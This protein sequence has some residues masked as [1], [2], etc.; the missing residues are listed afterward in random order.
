M[1]LEIRPASVTLSPRESQ[2]FQ[3]LENGSPVDAT[4]EI[5]PK[6]KGQLK[7][8]SVYQAPPFF[9]TSTRVTLVA[10]RNAD[11]AT[12]EILLNPTHLWIL[13][14][15]AY[16]LATTLIAGVAVYRLWPGADVPAVPAAVVGPALATLKPGE[17]Q[18]L[19]SSVPVTWT[20]HPG[21]VY[22]AP[23]AAPVQAGDAEF[24]TPVSAGG[25]SPEG[26]V[27]IVH[28]NDVSISIHPPLA[29]LKP[30]E[31]RQFEVITKEVAPSEAAEGNPPP[32]A[33]KRNLTAVWLKPEAGD[34]KD[35]VFTAPAA[36]DARPRT[37]LLTAHTTSPKRFAAAR[38]VLLP[39]SATLPILWLV[40]LF[41]ALGA[42]LHAINSL[43]AYV[44]NRKFAVSWAPFYLARPFAGAILAG[45]VFFVFR[46]SLIKDVASPTVSELYPA[47]AVAIL[48]GLFADKF[49]KKL[50]DITDALISSRP[51]ARTGKL[52]ESDTA[53]QPLVPAITAITPPSAQPGADA[54]EIALTGA[55]FQTGA[56]VSI[57]GVLRDCTLVSATQIKATLTAEDLKAARDVKIRVSSGGALSNEVVF[58]VAVTTTS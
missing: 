28:S 38:V 51:D 3:V 7:G 41:G 19:Q 53:A 35:G 40:L 9:F 20:S 29:L 34:L 13:I 52:G 50:E 10:T 1:A 36:A 26:A 44:G 32:S 16:W 4:F 49:L 37:I 15:G 42:N 31:K 46:A 24:L 39:P 22:T 43:A 30:G 11:Q 2:A 55:N 6:N 18:I 58:K 27:A 25:G 12:A 23:S 54:T 56:K 21:G 8:V 48:T 57:D 17:S 33:P 45:G 14:L 47:V 5:V